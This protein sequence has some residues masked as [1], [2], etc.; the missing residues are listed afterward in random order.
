MGL[1]QTNRIAQIEASLGDDPQRK[2]RR[3]MLAALALLLTALVLV[4]IKD[5]EFWF[6]SAPVVQS[7]SEP[8]SEP[9]EQAVPTPTAQTGAVSK[10]IHPVAA[11]RK[12]AKPHMPSAALPAGSNPAATPAPAV[13]SRAVLPPLQVEVVAGDKHRP[14]QGGT[15]SVKVD[16]QPQT[17]ASLSQAASAKRA[18]DSTGVTEAAGRV[19]LSTGAA[20]MVSRSVQPSYPLLAKQMKVE[21]AVVLNALIGRDGNIQQLQVLSGPTILSSAARQAVQQWRFKPYMQAGQAVETE[22][23]ITVNFTIW[24]R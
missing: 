5:R 22:S 14:V 1:M 7:E 10:T 11:A 13:A 16:L 18:S 9:I 19:R 21:G 23:R 15:N 2:V 4:L 3:Q 12:K 6:P 17:A 24:T 20:D 8:L